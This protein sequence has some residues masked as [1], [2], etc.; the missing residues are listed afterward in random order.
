MIFVSTHQLD[1]WL[2]DQ[3]KIIDLLKILPLQLQNSVMWDWVFSLKHV[4]KFQ[5]CSGRMG[6]MVLYHCEASTNNK[7]TNWLLTSRLLSNIVCLMAVSWY[8]CHVIWVMWQLSHNWGSMVVANGLALI[9][10]QDSCN[11]CDNAES[12]HKSGVPNVMVARGTW[13][14]KQPC[15]ILVN[16]SHVYTTKSHT[17]QIKS[18]PQA[19]M[20][21]FS[22]PHCIMYDV[23]TV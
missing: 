15:W 9:W 1:P 19:Y 12:Q 3:V 8:P 16:K 6:V 5:T 13:L 22:V 2:K 4:T 11:H 17:M 7:G 18:Q 20:H 10:H 23:I 14:T 21:L